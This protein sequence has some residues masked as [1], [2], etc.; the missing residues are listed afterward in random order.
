M[1]RQ[2]SIS[3]FDAS[4]DE[5]T[6]VRLATVSYELKQL[7]SEK[8]MLILQHDKELRDAQA[9]ADADFKRYQSSASASG[10]A[11]PAI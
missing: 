9:K 11:D 1:L 7:Q 8:D 5:N 6:R 10:K 4:G 2:P 3:K